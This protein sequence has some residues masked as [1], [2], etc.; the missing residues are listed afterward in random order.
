MIGQANHYSRRFAASASATADLT[1]YGDV[2]GRF[3]GSFRTR[4]ATDNN[5]V[6]TI[7]ACTIYTTVEVGGVVVFSHRQINRNQF[8]VQL[9]QY[10]VDNG[11]TYTNYVWTN[12]MAA[13]GLF[14]GTPTIIGSY[15]GTQV[16]P[17][18]GSGATF[19][20][21]LKSYQ[22][23]YFRP[24]NLGPSAIPNAYTPSTVAADPIA[25]YWIHPEPVYFHCNRTPGQS[26]LVRSALYKEVPLSTLSAPINDDPP[27]SGST[28]EPDEVTTTELVRIDGWLLRYGLPAETVAP[29]SGFVVDFEGE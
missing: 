8:C 6:V 3:W 1:P 5:A 20:N 27:A 26:V 22:N 28:L 7:P 14:T 19:L 25:G 29:V 15:T 10:G 2:T 24:A 13:G 11:T 12:I 18:G 4:I 16:N 23:A 9:F 17:A 21:P